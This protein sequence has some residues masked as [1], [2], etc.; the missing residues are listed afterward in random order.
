M[1]KKLLRKGSIYSWKIAEFRKFIES[2][3]EIDVLF[4]IVRKKWSK[5]I[6]KKW[7]SDLIKKKNEK[8]NANKISKKEIQ[9]IINDDDDDDDFKMNK[10]L[11]RIYFNKKIEMKI[12]EKNETLTHT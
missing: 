9:R 11:N 10:A 1:L 6:I 2:L 3:K 8:K 4:K 12:C 5:L 7:R